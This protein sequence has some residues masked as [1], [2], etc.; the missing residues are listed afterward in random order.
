MTG[1]SPDMDESTPLFPIATAAELSGLHPQTLQGAS[2][3][4]ASHA[5]GCSKK[6]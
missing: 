6:F 2:N 5:W 1:F 4:G 3:K